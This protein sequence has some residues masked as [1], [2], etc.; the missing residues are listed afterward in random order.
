MTTP[1]RAAREV[2]DLQSARIDI[3]KEFGEQGFRNG[4]NYVTDKRIQISSAQIDDEHVWH[5]VAKVKGTEAEPFTTTL[6]MEFFEFGIDIFAAECTCDVRLNCKHAA[7]LA[8]LWTTMQPQKTGTLTGERAEPIGEDSQLP[9]H[10]SAPMAPVTP[11]QTGATNTIRTGLSPD[12]S[13]WLRTSFEQSSTQ[14]AGASNDAKSASDFVAYLLTERGEITLAKARRLK[15]GETKLN[16]QAASL[17]W[18][19]HG[20]ATP[21]YV[22]AEDEP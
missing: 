5:L 20:H 15:G 9:E 21:A 1:T 3:E 14:D 4:I 17:S 13:Q 22:A 19:Y 8:Y 7:G 11:S 18:V 2:L 16:V 6:E 12:L 10:T